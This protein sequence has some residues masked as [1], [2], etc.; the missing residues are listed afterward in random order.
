MCLGPSAVAVMNGKLKTQV[1]INSSVI[2]T[3]LTR[4]S[5]TVIKYEKRAQVA[6]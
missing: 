5:H 4:Q 3:N 1:L 6:Q 2:C